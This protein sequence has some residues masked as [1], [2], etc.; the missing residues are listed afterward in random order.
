MMNDQAAKYQ[1]VIAKCWADETFRQRLMSDPGAVLA[2]EGIAVPAGVKV[3]VVADSPSG[4]TLVIPPR[5]TELSDAS[6]DGVA[7]GRPGHVVGI[8][9]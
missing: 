5:P 6:L 3:R 7:G 4:M 1:Q 2:A 8:W 9:G